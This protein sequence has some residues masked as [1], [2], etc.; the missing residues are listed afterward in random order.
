[1]INDSDFS[2]IES[3]LDGTLAKNDRASFEKR[4]RVEDELKESLS[5]MMEMDIVLEEFDK[6]QQIEEWK[7][8]ITTEPLPQ[9]TLIR[10]LSTIRHTQAGQ[11]A[12]SIAAML[13]LFVAIYFLVPNPANSPQQLANH[14]WSETAQFSYSNISRGE[15]SEVVE[16]SLEDIYTLHKTGDYTA[17]LK[18]I[19]ALPT[20]D[21]KAILLKG[22]CY[23]NTNQA[24]KAILAFQE[25]TAS[26]NNYSVDEAKWY[27]ALS[28]L[29][30]GDTKQ[31][32]KK[33]Q[34]IVNQKL[35]NNVSASKLLKKI[36]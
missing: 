5:L 12:L 9:P 30:K 13:L 35:W 25:I 16:N 11:Y 6:N 27:L 18:A 26:P 14:Y 29:K 24:D 34:E 22:S 17:T 23:Y 32:Q 21:E 2:L 7:N 20:L 3:Y 10:R 33:L 28:Y 36:Q 1:M 15:N 4:I 19:E 31:A 8:I